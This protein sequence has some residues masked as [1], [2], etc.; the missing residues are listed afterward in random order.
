MLCRSEDGR[1]GSG[2]LG[3]RVVQH[4]VGLVLR[5]VDRPERVGDLGSAKSALHIGRNTGAKVE[6][7]AGTA[8]DWT[9]HGTRHSV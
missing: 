3:G 5:C 4:G 6:G 2:A 1:A 7:R 9:G 8:L